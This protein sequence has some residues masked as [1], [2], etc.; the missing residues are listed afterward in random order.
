MEEEKHVNS[1]QKLSPHNPQTTQ[2]ML[3][4]HIGS[5]CFLTTA[6]WPYF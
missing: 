2:N 1:G 4:V 3:F 5:F 6:L